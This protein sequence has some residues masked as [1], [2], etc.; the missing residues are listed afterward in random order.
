MRAYECVSCLFTSIQDDVL[1][2]RILFQVNMTSNTLFL[3]YFSGIAS[4]FDSQGNIRD[5]EKMRHNI[6]DFLTNFGVT[7]LWPYLDKRGTPAVLSVLL[8]GHVVGFVPSS[9]VENV[10]AELRRFKVSATSKVYFC[11][12]LFAFT[13]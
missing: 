7:P 13:P 12:I 4:Y 8:D 1:F 2:M 5:F 10:V 6:V 11:Q 3:L 9:E